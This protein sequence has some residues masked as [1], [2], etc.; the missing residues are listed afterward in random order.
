MEESWRLAGTVAPAD[1]EAAMLDGL[2]TRAAEGDDGAFEQIYLLLV[3]DIYAFVRGHCREAATAEDI[4]ATVFMHAWRSAKAYHSGSQQ[5]RRWIFTIARNEL[6]THWRRSAASPPF[7][8]IDERYPESRADAG[9]LNARVVVHEALT[10]LTDEQRN[11]VVLRYFDNRS[12]EEIAALVG[13]REGAVR[14]LLMRALHRMRGVL[15]D[16]A[17]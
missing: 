10:T 8:P 9:E 15:L 13:K 4:V 11:V 14:A 16:E 12:H 6:R 17:E 1:R 5:F 3:D 7:Q 2:A